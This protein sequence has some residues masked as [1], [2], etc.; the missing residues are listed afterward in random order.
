MIFRNLTALILLFFGT[1]VV[2]ATEK[3]TVSIQ[4][5]QCLEVYGSFEAALEAEE[6]ISIFQGC[7]RRLM[8]SDDRKVFV[9]LRAS[10]SNIKTMMRLA[11]ELDI[12]AEV[13]PTINV[14]GGKDQKPR[15]IEIILGSENL[16]QDD[17][18]AMLVPSIH[19]PNDPMVRVPRAEYRFAEEVWDL[20]SVL[21]LSLRTLA[22][23]PQTVGKQYVT[24]IINESCDRWCQRQI[25]FVLDNDGLVERTYDLLGGKVGSVRDLVYSE[26]N[27][28][29]QGALVYDASQRVSLRLDATHTF[30]EDN[31][32]LQ[33][34]VT[35]RRDAEL[36][37]YNYPI[38]TGLIQLQ[39]II[40]NTAPLE[41]SHEAL[42]L[43]ETS[44]DFQDEELA[45]ALLTG[46]HQSLLG[47]LPMPEN[48][49]VHSSQVALNYLN[50]AF[51]LR[52]NLF[53]GE[54]S[55][56][57]Q[58][59]REVA[60]LMINHDHSKRLIPIDPNTCLFNPEAWVDTVQEEAKPKIVNLSQ[61]VYL[62]KESCE[63]RVSLSPDFLWV[64][65]AGNSG[66]DGAESLS[67]CPQNLGPSDHL[68]VVAAGNRFALE[69]YSDR[70]IAYA[71]LIASGKG[72]EQEGSS[73][74]T[75][76]V[77]EVA[78]TMAQRH[79]TVMDLDDTFGSKLTPTLMKKI[80]LL[81]VD[82]PRSNCQEPYCLRTQQVRS[83]GSL[84]RAKAL[85]GA[86]L[87]WGQMSAAERQRLAQGDPFTAL[88]FFLNLY[89]ATEAYERLLVFTH[90]QILSTPILNQGD[91]I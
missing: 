5:N 59:S 75:A 6:G 25:N 43:C 63:N 62:T 51:P 66:R 73:M 76:R 39:E 36:G 38:A 90:S 77:S 4:G 58:H 17:I 27:M 41:E 65:G 91:P 9:S 54:L 16:T 21:G 23:P 33:L 86:D 15:L 30:A 1:S 46:P 55:S 57:K 18:Q 10:T 29:P 56:A 47:W 67:R 37:V 2:A 52:A 22:Q 26:P 64:T 44:Y 50:G 35:S 24:N 70:G 7:L 80:I 71:D 83:G 88:H 49:G 11:Y 31:I 13:D 87:A 40:D 60:K 61:T 45:Q 3:G 72:E 81:T 74:A 14:G 82:I 79:R 32:S 85:K 8:M 53:P 12:L 69:P 48:T 89:P 78:A 84:D 68:L 19:D 20:R 28:L 42:I 34:T